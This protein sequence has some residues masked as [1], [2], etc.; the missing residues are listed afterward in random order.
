MTAIN[1][2]LRRACIRVRCKKVGPN[3]GPRFTT[4]PDT[5]FA[6][7]ASDLAASLTDFCT[8]AIT[9]RYRTST[10]SRKP[11]IGVPTMRHMPTTSTNVHKLI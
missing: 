1:L 5:V 3:S 10:M 7:L 8:P 2:G 6:T 11:L 9:T 4:D